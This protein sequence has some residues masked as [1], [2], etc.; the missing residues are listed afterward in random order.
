MTLIAL[1]SENPLGSAC[2][3]ENDMPDRAQYSP[4]LASLYVDPAH[5]KQGLATRLISDIIKQAQLL[6]LNCIY[7]FTPDQAEFYAKR[8][9][10]TIEQRQY[11]GVNVDI[12]SYLIRT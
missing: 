4:W 11:H 6:G 7:L 3:L 8:G 5:R 2:L 12:M 1:D 9:W 10:K